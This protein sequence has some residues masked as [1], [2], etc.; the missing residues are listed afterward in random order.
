MLR[1]F[2]RQFEAAR[3]PRHLGFGRACAAVMSVS[4]PTMRL[5]RPSGYHSTGLPR[6]EIQ[7]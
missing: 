3:Q 6:L 1:H 2:E 7:M 4:V 5:G